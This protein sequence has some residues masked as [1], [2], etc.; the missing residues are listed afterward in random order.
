[1]SKK[2][3]LGRGLSALL[4]NIETDITTG[5]N[6]ESTTR[7]LGSVAMLP[8]ESIETNPFQPRTVF[9]EDSLD[10]LSQSIAQHG[11]IQPVTVRKMG[12]D[13][14]QLIS[15][16]RRF[17]ASKRAGIT[18]LP[19]Y[20]RVANDQTMLEMALVENIQRRDLDP[21]EIAISYRRLLEECALTQDALSE[22]VGKKR[23]TVTNYLRLLKLPDAVQAGLRENKLS[24]GHARA[25]INLENPQR[26][27]EIYA[28]IIDQNLSVR[29]VE[30]LVKNQRPSAKT[31][32][33]KKPIPLSFEHQKL[34]D[35]LSERLNTRI[36]LK[37]DEKG[38]GKIEIA[39]KSDADLQRI[40]EKLEL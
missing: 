5:S 20:I 3:G 36:G 4:E 15:G 35:D 33:K 38:R 16:E 22:K 40:I 28:Q 32:A 17:R 8:I 18:E 21:I 23:S 10:E 12:Y 30:E 14:F 29:Q 31:P 25:L 11:I 37:R 13:R 39:F 9:D 1:M 6:T 19:A 7:V 27:L 2:K 24:M 34:Q 26:L